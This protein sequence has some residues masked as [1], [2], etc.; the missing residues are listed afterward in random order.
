M[1]TN[2]ENERREIGVR[3]KET[4]E[5]LGLSQDE[6]AKA[7]KMPRPAVSL[8]ENGERKVDALELKKFAALFD[9]SVEYFV[10]GPAKETK[11][12]PVFLARASKDVRSLAETATELSPQ[13]RN[14]LAR[15]AEYLRAKSKPK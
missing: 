10:S 2:E 3:L 1:A 12:E 14:E 13:D 8:I 11:K 7:L 6:V 15:F 5:Y 4:R 9:Q